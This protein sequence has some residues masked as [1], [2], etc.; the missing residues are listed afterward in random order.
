METKVFK[1][2]PCLCPSVR[3]TP[4]PSDLPTPRRTATSENLLYRAP[5]L[6]L[7]FPMTSSLRGPRLVVSAV[8]LLCCLWSCREVWSGVLA[9]E[10]RASPYVFL[11]LPFSL[12]FS[13]A[14]LFR[15]TV[16]SGVT[17]ASYA[18]FFSDSGFVL[19]YSLGV[20]VLQSFKLLC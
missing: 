5:L 14:K 1:V 16:L 2:A 4:S 8:C 15:S 9:P 6:L 20:G 3:P 19:G 18:G 17:V 13:H 10:L 11:N 12:D 7:R